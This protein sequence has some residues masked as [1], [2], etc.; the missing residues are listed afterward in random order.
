VL[1][2][3]GRGRTDA[4]TFGQPG[5]EIEFRVQGTTVVQ[6]VDGLVVR[7]SD[8]FDYPGVLSS[9]RPVE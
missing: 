4:A 1:P 8:Y 3:N 6:I 7:H 9:V 2:L 5:G